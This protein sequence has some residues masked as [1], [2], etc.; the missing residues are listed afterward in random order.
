ME[1]ED[2]DVLNLLRDTTGLSSP[3]KVTIFDVT[4]HSG[5]GRKYEIILHVHDHGPDSHPGRFSAVIFHKHDPSRRV[6][7]DL[8]P[9]IA[10]ALAKLRWSEL[11]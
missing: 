1:A 6:A 5:I 7:S 10:A 11:D 2:I 4:R 3:A 8:Y 9:D